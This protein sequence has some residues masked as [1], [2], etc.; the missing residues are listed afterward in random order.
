MTLKI[1]HF[2][3]AHNAKR[4][5]GEGYT[6]NIA[7]HDV[8]WEYCAWHGG[9][10]R[11]NGKSLKINELRV[12]ALLYIHIHTHNKTRRREKILV[13]EHKIFMNMLKIKFFHCSPTRISHPLSLFELCTRR[14]CNS[15][16]F[17]VMVKKSSL[18]GQYSLFFNQPPFLI[19]NF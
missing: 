9:E 3:I 10:M 2:Y 19:F 4:R 5:E 11:I 8:I 14:K 16:L 6:H 15:F 12:Y 7:W 1:A 13:A 17:G 18:H